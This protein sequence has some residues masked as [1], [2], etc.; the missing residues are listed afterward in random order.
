MLKRSLKE[1]VCLWWV[2]CSTLL[3]KVCCRVWV[4]SVLVWLYPQLSGAGKTLLALSLHSA[5]GPHCEV[6]FPFYVYDTPLWKG[7]SKMVG[8][9][10]SLWAKRILFLFPSLAFGLHFPVLPAV[11]SFALLNSPYEF[12]FH[13]ISRLEWSR[14]KVGDCLRVLMEKGNEEKLV[15]WTSSQN[16][17]GQK[18]QQEGMGARSERGALLRVAQPTRSIPGPDIAGT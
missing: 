8:W 7:W 10:L 17:P 1:K 6:S 11:L 18:H 12:P 15:L 5:C 13:E 3:L 16:W 9:N 4:L 14:S 2:L